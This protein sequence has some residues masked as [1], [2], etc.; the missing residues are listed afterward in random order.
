[1]LNATLKSLYAHKLRLALTALA[2]VLGVAFMSGT[3]VL[4][5]TIK[6]TFD[7]LFQQTSAGKD[8]VVRA[9]APYGD[10]GQNG[11]LF[12]NR[13]LTP[14]SLVPTVQSTPGVAA[15]EGSVSGEVVAL[16]HNGKTFNT[17]APTLAFSWFTDRQLSALHLKSGRAP[18]SASEI[19]IDAATAKKQHFALGDQITI[20]GNQGPASYTLVG[21]TGFGSSDNLAGAT[22]VSFDLPTAQRVAGKPG[23]LNEIDVAAV[24][25]TSSQNLLAA[26]GARLPKGFEVVTGAEAAAE[27]ANTVT[28]NLNQ[29]NTILLVFAGVA[30]FVGAFLIFNTFS[31]LVGQRT[32]ELSLL[33]AIGASR[34]Q[35]NVSVLGEAFVTG[36]VGSLVG[37]ALG[38]AL[39]AGLYALLDALGVSLP[40][41]SLQFEARTVIVGLIVG[42]VVTVA[43]AIL[44]AARAGRIP[45]AAGLREDAVIQETSLRRR[46]IVGG[47]VLAVGVIVLAAGLFAHAGILAVGVGAAVTFIGVAMLAP[48]VVGP[49]VQVLGRPLPAIAG[50][51]GELGMEN[52]A[53]NPRRT[54]ATASALMVGLALVAAIA[55][56]GQSATASFN[57]LF[58]KSIKATYV[59]S[60]TGL[61]TISPAAEPTVRAVPGVTAVSPVRTVQW[62]LG[63]VGK[64]LTGIDPIGGPQIFNINMVTGSVTALAKGEVLIDNTVAKNDHFRVGEVL[65]MGFAATGVQQVV[66]GGT[67]KTNQFLG[68]YTASNA[69]IA[70]NVNQV[71][72]EVIGVKTVTTSPAMAAALEAAMRPYAN[73]KVQTAAQFKSDQKKQL[74]SIL[75]IVYALLGL[76]IV[77]ALIGVVNTLALSVMERTREIGLL[78]AVGMQR[79]QLKRMIRG[80]S[81]IVSL[82]GAIMGL[83]LGVGLGA[84]VVSALSSSF[85]TQL[86]IPVS[87]IIVVLILATIF[88]VIAAVWPARRAAKLDVLQAIYTV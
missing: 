41:S 67:Y 11:D 59:L 19:A 2:V 31:I 18:T 46:A 79:R 28:Q 87:T 88:G 54:A 70:A 55:T 75:S 83:V 45:P 86:A 85:I 37:L 53:R 66:I 51:S 25:G 1:M 10:T 36:L 56:L 72:D 33:R 60:P 42:T 62:H 48:F 8:A 50:V 40:R 15:A 13:P 68:N 21:I 57:S 23:Y 27:E 74:N 49:L 80:E 16:G 7:A 5:D 44:P 3:F 81:L 35:I 12:G 76:S 4:T 82:I 22:V 20:I 77:I 9:I 38:V 78:R 32:R 26:I 34:R 39:A 73:V 24:P 14:E 84:A 43:S 61:G 64:Q 29:F 47:A 65:P 17:H 30:L 63:H 58:N 52:A 6:H 71:Q 69:L